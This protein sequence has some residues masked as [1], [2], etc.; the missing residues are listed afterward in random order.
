MTKPTKH[1]PRRLARRRPTILCLL[2]LLPA[3]G[4]C[5]AGSATA[6]ATPSAAALESV[7]ISVGPCFGFCPVYDAAIASNGAVTFTGKR[8]TAVLGERR[9]RSRFGTYS[10]VTTALA[11][12]RPASGTTMRVECSA[13]ILDTAPYTITWTDANG[14]RTVATHRSRCSG[15]TGKELDALLRDLPQQ[16]G[17]ADWARQTTRSGA[18]RG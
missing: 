2:T 3:F 12:F 11:R 4:G 5:A 8:H 1:V 6:V 9:G 15:G 7:T 10:A 17:I 18:S 16:L 13:E 14:Q